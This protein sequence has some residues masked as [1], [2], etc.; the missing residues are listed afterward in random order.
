MNL[1]FYLF[2]GLVGGFC[3][4]APVGPINLY[5]AATA[6]SSHHKGRFFFLCGVIL[7][8]LLFA[9]VAFSG[10]GRYF[11]HSSLE[12]YFLLAGGGLLI[13]LA[14]STLRTS[15][16]KLNDREFSSPVL[17]QGR[18]F[19]EG[20]ALCATNPGFLAFWIFASALLL[21]FSH[22]AFSFV[23]L[24][25]FLIGVLLGDVLWFCLF[26]KLIRWAEGKIQTHVLEK[27]A[28]TIAVL[29]AILGLVGIARG[30]W[31]LK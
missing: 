2:G 5:V 3:S 1:A 27:V 11:S 20:L 4:S 19:I 29:L 30:V 13:F 10:Y 16:S 9:A 6:G 24:I 14:I 25:F 28:P 12:P 22:S 26:I 7:A 15:P 18:A 23:T 17:S 21:E 31:G 8:D